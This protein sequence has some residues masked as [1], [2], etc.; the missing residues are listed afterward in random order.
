[1]QFS[2]MPYQRSFQKNLMSY[3]AYLALCLLVS[4]LKFHVSNS[5]K[6][7]EYLLLLWKR[8]AK[9]RQPKCQ[10]PCSCPCP[11]P[12]INQALLMLLLFCAL[13]CLCGCLSYPLLSYCR[14]CCLYASESARALALF[15]ATHIQPVAGRVFSCALSNLF[16]ARN[17]LSHL[18]SPSRCLLSLN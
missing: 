15:Y 9:F 11:C 14:N 3:F 2:N 12:T 17:A 18:C 1:M 6:K 7:K 4:N 16:L 8:Q 5:K 13:L 10:G